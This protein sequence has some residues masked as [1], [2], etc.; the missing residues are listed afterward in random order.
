MEKAKY[1]IFNQLFIVL[2]LLLLLG[3]G[4]LGVLAFRR[5]EAALF[6][7][8]Q[9]NAR[10]I[11]QCAAANVSGDI[12]QEIQEGEEGSEAYNAIIEELA[13]F[14]DNAELEY[15]Y[16][17]RKTSD[18]RFLFVVDSDPEEPA[19]IGDECEYTEALDLAFTDRLTLADDEPF[20]DEWGMHVSA[21]SPVVYK[22]AVVGAVGV[23]ISANWIEEQTVTLRNLVIVTC[24]ITYAISLLILVLIMSKFKRSMGKLNSKVKELASGSGDLTKEIDIYSKDEFGAIAANMNEFIR[25]IRTLVNEVALSTK[26][27]LA[28]G[29]EVNVTVTDNARIMSEMNREI[30]DISVDMEQSATSGKELSQNL[31]ESAK[32]MA[33]FTQ[34]VKK[35]QGIVQKAN[36]NAKEASATAKGNRAEALKEIEALQRKVMKTNED[37]QKIQQVKQIAEE[38]GAIAGQTRMLSLNAQIEAARAGASGAGF[39]VVAEQ[40]GSLSDEIDRAVAE[41]NATNEQVLAALGAWT[42]ASEEMLRFVSEDVV[43]AYDAF[44]G[45]GE[46]YGDTTNTIHAQMTEIGTQS[47]DILQGISDISEDVT[48]IAAT[49]TKT[50]ESANDLAH[51][52]GKIS[53]S[54]EVLNA[55]T[56]KNVQ[57]SGKLSNQ[58]S[59][60]SF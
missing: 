15:I 2:S 36:E 9:S 40:V 28:T 20:S 47:A 42:E 38:I 30:G 31:S 21:Y 3:N 19:A 56:Q 44:A 14:R 41:I 43:K 5:S 16:T 13:L 4:I 24:V 46:E 10:N 34:S 53:E 58:V 48:R 54:L 7:Q 39:A 12:L 8:I 11:A 35:I 23:D 17:L 60:Y 59:R 26:E 22:D 29:E 49:V 18:G 37:A 45:L 6:G 27:I 55:T 51:S 32:Q 33:A 25:Q 50:A 52:T 1:S 57:S